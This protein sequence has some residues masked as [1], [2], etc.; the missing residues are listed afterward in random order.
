MENKDKIKEADKSFKKGKSAVSTGLLKWS[1][2]H[3]SASMH[4]EQA[5]K[6]YKET[7]QKDKSKDAWVKYA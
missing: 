7:G 3:L 5:A 4:F 1:A 2:D 6:L